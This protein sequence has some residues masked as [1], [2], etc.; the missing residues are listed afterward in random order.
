[1]LARCISLNIPLNNISSVD[2][3]HRRHGARMRW[4]RVHAA[5]RACM[6]WRRALG[7][8]TPFPHSLSCASPL[9]L[10]SDDDQDE[11][12]AAGKVV[13]KRYRRYYMNEFHDKL[14]VS[15]MINVK[16]YGRKD[17]PFVHWMLL[18]EWHSQ[19]K[20]ESLHVRPK[21]F[22]LYSTSQYFCCFNN[23][24]EW[25]ACEL[26]GKGRGKADPHSPQALTSH[27]QDW[28]ANKFGKWQDIAREIA[29]D[30]H[31]QYVSLLYLF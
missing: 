5:A 21:G 4:R 9:C 24:A 10:M 14:L 23:Q 17:L 20:N 15:V 31:P 29:N 19:I 18:L 11:T 1:M 28:A 13:N 22:E 27:Y 2:F 3:L 7:L 6:R 26:M 8:N 25:H 16:A 30:I 12:V